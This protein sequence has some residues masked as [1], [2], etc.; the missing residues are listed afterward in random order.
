[1]FSLTKTNMKLVVDLAILFSGDLLGCQ[2]VGG[3]TKNVFWINYIY[4]YTIWTNHREQWL[5]GHCDLTVFVVVMLCILVA[6]CY[7]DTVFSIHQWLNSKTSLQHSFQRTLIKNPCHS[8]RLCD[9]A[10]YIIIVIVFGN[11]NPITKK[12]R[13]EFHPPQKQRN[14]PNK[15]T[16]RA[17]LFVHCSSEPVEPPKN[18]D[19]STTFCR[20]HLSSLLGGSAV[21]PRK[22]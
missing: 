13:L 21:F 16:I 1:M 14:P 22:V 19:A 9:K 7:H 10:T 3:F 17:F 6:W 4:I 8:N 5:V 2:V 12:K 15:P 20:H 18:P 11:T